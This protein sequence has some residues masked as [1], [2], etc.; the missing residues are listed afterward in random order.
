MTSRGIAQR[1]LANQHIAS[2][3]FDMPADEVKWLVAVQAQDYAS[4][5]W[6][7]GL[8]LQGAVEGDI[9]QAFNAGAILR[10]HLMR[11]TWHLVTPAD[12]RWLLALTAPRVHAANAYMGYDEY[13]S[14]YKDRSAIVD[15][16]HGA[17]LIAMGNALNYVVVVSGQIVGTWKRT[18]SKDAVVIET[19]LFRSLT[20]LENRAVASAADQY[21]RFVGLPVE[22]RHS[23]T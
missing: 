21:C 5:K 20:Q 4:A 9:E 16:K 19:D 7:L 1:R 8:R 11:P 22:L 3:A 18:F 2:P 13:I 15:A 14:A 10:T 12:I 17:K 6:S 23:N